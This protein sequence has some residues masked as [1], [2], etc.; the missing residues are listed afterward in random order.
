MANENFRFNKELLDRFI[1][2]AQPYFFPL[3]APN[4][5]LRLIVLL[6][7]SILFVMSI[8]YFGIISIGAI[9][10]SFYPVFMTDVAPNFKLYVENLKSTN[11]SIIS[12]S[13]ICISILLFKYN[14][15]YIKDKMKPWLLIIGILTLLFC[16]TGL[17]VSLSYIFRFLDTSL[18]VRNE[19]AF[20][21]FLWVYGLIVLIALPI[22][23]LYRFT[24]LKF[25]RY[26]REWLTNN[27]IER[28]FKNRA[29]YL[30]DS[31]A[32]NSDIDNPDQRIS[33]DIKNF[34][35]VTLNF[36]IDIL[37]AILTVTAFSAILWSISKTLTIGLLVYVGLGT[38]V[39]IYT[40]KKMIKIYYDQLRLEADFRYGLIHVRDNSESIAF[41]SGEK[42]EIKNIL[43]RLYSALKNYDLWIIWQSIVDLFQFSYS[44]LM[45]FPVYLLVAPLYFSGQIDFGTITQAWIAFFQVF[46]ALSIVTNQIESISAF[47]ASIFRLGNFDKTLTSIANSSSNEPCIRYAESGTLEFEKVTVK[48]PDGLRV[49]VQNLSFSLKKGDRMM[50]VGESG[51]GKSSLL[52][53]VAGLWDFGSGLIKKPSLSKTM[54]LPQQPYMLLG[55]LKE[56]ISYPNSKDEFDLEDID[57]VLRRVGLEQLVKDHN[58]NEVKDW[59]RVLSVGEQQRLAFARVLLNE[60]EFVILD[61]GTSALDMENEKNLYKILNELDISYISVGHR[62]EIKQFHNSILTILPKGSYKL[63]KN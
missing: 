17:N 39:A 28:Y 59:T 12:L 29:Y 47:S 37:Q 53:S 49:L 58:V 57:K 60:P 61:E 44:N 30:L 15:C 22:I 20:W 63:D 56:Q 8:C 46:G 5:S 51:I 19:N 14:Y 54:F 33:E 13:V 40:G 26:W 48:T 27:F 34:T 50:I 11:L 9:I 10:Q 45:R 36:L 43:R 42:K 23:S 4:S 6:V 24:R 62:K 18:N 35:M 16:V 38:W 25:G 3:N 55:T 31:N 1:S 7:S 21:D 32:Q 52:R 2:I 41:Y